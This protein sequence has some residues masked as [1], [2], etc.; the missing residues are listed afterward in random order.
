[1]TR[2]RWRGVLVAVVVAILAAACSSL[3]PI[4]P[5]EQANGVSESGDGGE[6]QGQ[7]AEN[8]AG[9]PDSVSDVVS[10]P[11][12]ANERL[13]AT[14]NLGAVFEVGRGETWGPAFEVDDLDAIA[15]AGFTAVR[16]PARWSDW[17]AEDAPYAIEAEF[18]ERIRAVV[19]R[20]LALDLGVVIN[21][22]H[23]DA[24][25]ADPV[26][27]RDR[28]LAIWRQLA[29]EFADQP[30]SV[31]FEILNEPNGLL[32]DQAWNDLAADA[33]AVI[34]QSNPGRTLMVGPAEWYRV[35]DLAR[36]E[37]PVDD[38]LIA[39]FHYYE[40]FVFTHQGAGFVEGA[41]AWLGTPWGS[42]EDR[43]RI[44]EQFATAA[45]WAADREVPVFLGEFGVLSE[46]DPTDRFEWIDFIRR[47]AE[48]LDFSWGYWDWATIDFGAFDAA[49]DDWN[50]AIIDA[51]LSP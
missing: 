38:N 19:E 28:F 43:S 31:V 23:Y 16:V 49:S 41:D 42:D 13:R 7:L 2:A 5:V 29:S 33:V 6:G 8:A 24:V 22:H 50:P 45:N 46:A 18:L 47:E 37:L 30:A 9:T 51:L 4:D 17:A 12:E 10:D 20:A 3:E 48:A 1:M 11:W 39:S 35:R 27:E 40:P 34:R 36:L 32:V 25:N 26:A 15:A 21:I 14:L 44:I